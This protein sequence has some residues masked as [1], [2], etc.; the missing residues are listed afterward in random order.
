MGKIAFVFPGQGAQSVGMGR[1]LYEACPS[2]KAVYDLCGDS[3]KQLS[4]EGP[5]E[6]LNMTVNAQPC[7]FAADLAAACALNEG[8]IFADGAAGF[9]L[10]EIPAAAHCGLMSHDVAFEL[11]C[12]RARV[13]QE[14]TQKYPGSMLAV[15]G[16][17]GSA[18]TEICKRIEGAW[19]VNFNAPG[20]TIVALQEN[21]ADE[22]KAAVKSGAGKII[23]LAVSGGFHSPLMDEAAEQLKKYLANMTFNNMQIPLYANATGQLYENPQQLLSQQVN[24]PVRWQMLIEQMIADGF[25]T[26]IETGPGKTLT[27][28]IKKINKDVRTFN[29]FDIDSLKTVVLELRS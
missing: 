21:A 9:S 13:M 24:H 8:G 12:F 26:F 22:L 25:D 15:L 29:V 10:G 4:F 1:N 27:G 11:V 5:Q 18:V 14:C 17:D 7:L 6:T 23:P 2:A 19:P 28:L 20:Q 16:L 3:V